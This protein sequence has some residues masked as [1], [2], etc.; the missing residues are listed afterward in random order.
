MGSLAF[1][2]MVNITSQQGTSLFTA[3]L[4]FDDTSQAEDEESSLPHLDG[5]QSKLPPGILPHG[6]PQ[7]K[8]VQPALTALESATM[9]QE[10]V[11]QGESTVEHLKMC[12][13]ERQNTGAFIVSYAFLSRKFSFVAEIVFE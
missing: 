7:V 9:K 6:L 5:F 1:F 2:K 4:T 12:N 10:P 11:K 8:E 13:A 3:V